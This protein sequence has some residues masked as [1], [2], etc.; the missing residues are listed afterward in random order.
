MNRLYN[1]GKRRI[2][3]ITPEVINKVKMLLKAKS[4]RLIAMEL[5]ISQYTVMCISQGK[6]DTDK[7]L[8][9]D[10]IIYQS[11]FIHQ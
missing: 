11:N 5:N 8:Q 6:Y 7:P 3:T 2:G 1:N 4:Q 9:Y 10:R